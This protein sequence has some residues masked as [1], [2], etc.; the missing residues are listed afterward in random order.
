M[1]T[2]WTQRFGRVTISIEC[3][4]E[5]LRV[6]V[7]WHKTPEQVGHVQSAMWMRPDGRPTGGL[8]PVY[9]NN[10]DVWICPLP[11]LSIHIRKDV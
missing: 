1:K 9:E 10:L 5:D 2:F 4:I 3:K 6:G 8:T 11:C 7:S